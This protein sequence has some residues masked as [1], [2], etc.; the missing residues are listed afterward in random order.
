MLA[1]TDG[2]ASSHSSLVNNGSVIT[3]VAK[4]LGQWR[5]E[6]KD[7]LYQ[8]LKDLSSAISKKTPEYRTG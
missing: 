8:T 1:T 4:R 6:L 7:A 2:M 5:P 3:L